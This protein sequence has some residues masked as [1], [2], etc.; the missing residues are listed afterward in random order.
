[1]RLYDLRPDE[2]LM[3]DDLKPGYD[4]AH[5]CGVHVRLRGLVAR[6]PQTALF[7][8]ASRFYLETVQ[9]LDRCCLV[10]TNMI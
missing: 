7:C 4:M 6:R 10:L 5:A 8:A 9:E 2:L 1:M 3:V